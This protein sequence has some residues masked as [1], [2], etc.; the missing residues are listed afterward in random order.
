MAEKDNGKPKKIV[1]VTDSR[2]GLV[3]KIIKK[4]HPVEIVKRK[5]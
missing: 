5:T 3:T 4:S 1:I 2:S